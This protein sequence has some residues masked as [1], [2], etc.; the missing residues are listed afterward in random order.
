MKSIYNVSYS[1]KHHSLPFTST[2]LYEKLL[3][4]QDTNSTSREGSPVQDFE[5][6][7]DEAEILG[8]LTMHEDEEEDGEELFGDNME[9]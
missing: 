3:K 6:F 7:E 8:E 9:A 5:P 4:L 2:K 1:G